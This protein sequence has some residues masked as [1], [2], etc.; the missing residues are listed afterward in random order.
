[1]RVADKLLKSPGQQVIPT[2]VGIMGVSIKCLQ[3]VFCHLQST[4]PWLTDP[5]VVELPW[6]QKKEIQAGDKS[7]TFGLFAHDSIVTPHPPIQRA[8]QVV[9]ES[10]R[11]SEYQVRHD[12]LKPSSGSN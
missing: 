7:V 9:E 10:L 4:Q 2:V 12:T 8:I 11:A 5:D 1:M 6:R 3:T